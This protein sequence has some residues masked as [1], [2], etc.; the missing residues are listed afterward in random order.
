MRRLKSI[1]PKA[2]TIFRGDNL[3]IMKAMPDE[4]VDLIYIDPPF[5]TQKDYKN[6]WGDKESVQDFEPPTIF[7]FSDKSDYFERHV[8]N[9]AKGL[10]AYLEWMR[11]RLN[12]LHRILKPTGSIFV[13]LDDH[14][15][16]Y[17]KVV[18]DDIFGYSNFCNEIVWKRVTNNKA[19][20]DGMF[21]RVHDT[22]LFY[23]KSGNTLFNK[24]YLKS[25][26]AKDLKNYSKIE[27]GTGRRYGTFDFTQAGPGPARNFRGKMLAPPKGKHWIWSQEKI[28]K[29]FREKK[30]VFSANGI[31][32]VKRYLDEKKGNLLGDMWADSDVLP[33]Q[34]H[35][36]EKT[37]YPTQ[38]P[39]RLLERMIMAAS[40]EGDVVFDCFAG[41]GS[42]M[43]AAHNLKRKWIGIDISPTAIKVNKKRLEELGAKVSV[44]DEEDLVVP[45]KR[46]G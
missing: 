30:I 23:R 40:N 7:S 17:I 26:D 38:K 1:H 41:C 16:H 15:V 44:V 22:V 18:L 5:F 12:E 46:A 21:A 31:P 19:Q 43:H 14:A 36:V 8:K 4:C 27:E 25:D 37:G 32:R 35:E 9:G 45:L 33:I 29:G 6:I 42:T 34:A 20:T 24:I 11:V 10:S 39:V 3:E 13:H 2:N 28:D